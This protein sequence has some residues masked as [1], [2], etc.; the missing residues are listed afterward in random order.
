MARIYPLF[1][2]LLTLALLA[3]CGAPNAAPT[4]DVAATVAAQVAATAQALEASAPTTVPAAPT[5]DVAATVAAQ[6][7]ATA[8]ALQANAPTNAPAPGE[9]PATQ[10]TAAPAGPQAGSQSQP[11]PAAAG[12][13]VPGEPMLLAIGANGKLS[14]LANGAWLQPTFNA[15]F[16]DSCSTSDASAGFDDLGNAW[17]GCSGAFISTDG[18][19][20]AAPEQRLYGRL[21]FD[22]QGRIWAPSSG[23]LVVVAN[24]APTEYKSLTTTG[25]EYYPSRALAFASDGST[26][27]SGYNSKGSPLVRF[28][29]TN[30]Q[31][32][33]Q[34]GLPYDSAPDALLATST[35][36]LLAATGEGLFKLN[37]EAFAL[38]I[39]KNRFADLIGA[40][41]FGTVHDLIETPA[42]EIWMATEDG[43]FVVG[44]DEQISIIDREAGLPANAVRDLAID[45]QGRVWAATAYGIAVQN[46]QAW[47]S[48]VLSTS[49]L[50]DSDFVAIAVR[51]APELPPA[52]LET[53]TAS[54]SGRI[55]QAGKPLAEAVVELCSEAVGN[56]ERSASDSPCGG[57][58]FSAQATTDSEGNYR[59]ENVPI[60]TYT[61]AVQGADKRWYVPFFS[62][63]SIIALVGGENVTE[64]IDLGN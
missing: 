25:D 14:V 5:P 21:F 45:G 37:G 61:L 17:A 62:R 8:Q 19:T 32:F 38:F 16:P 27:L 46:G 31:T 52:N 39:A 34:I 1:T 58:Y 59:F 4:P 11:L 56:N 2:L 12:S 60:G 28:D 40:Y 43:I 3:G 24:G 57:Q 26:W 47:Q 10:P 7:A 42:G 53:A 15:R 51:G 20:W 64:D 63:K 44:P 50:N 35:G 13:T 33:P 29:G 48:A 36:D 54:V 49:G 9:A 55:V 23:D 18:V 41:S 30:W 6:V 22:P